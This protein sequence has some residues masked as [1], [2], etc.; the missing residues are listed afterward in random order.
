MQAAFCSAILSADLLEISSRE[1]LC[2]EL[3]VP[4]FLPVLHGEQNFDKV[5]VFREMRETERDQYEKPDEVH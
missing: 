4:M 2:S 5:R 3:V 1:K